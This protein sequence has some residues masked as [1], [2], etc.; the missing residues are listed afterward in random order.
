MCFAGGMT[1]ESSSDDDLL[2]FS[3]TMRLSR[4]DAA[5]RLHEI[6]DSLARHNKLTF[7]REGMKYTVDV[8]K[9][10]ELEIEL[11]M[12]GD[13]TELEIELRW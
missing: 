1:D 11:E 6:A 5:K 10:I 13:G 3:E 9:E 7:D 8:P 12:G 2:E 4:E